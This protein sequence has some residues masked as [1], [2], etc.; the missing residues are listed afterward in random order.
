MQSTG[1]AGTHLPQPEH[2]S[3]TISTVKRRRSTAANA[4]GHALWHASQLMQYALSTRNG[5]SRHLGCRLRV[6]MRH[7]RPAVDIR[8]KL[9]D[10]AGYV[11]RVTGQTAHPFLSSEWIAEARVIHEAHRGKVQSKPPEIRLNLIVTEVPFGEGT[12]DAHVDTMSGE[13][14]VDLGHLRDAD[15]VLTLGYDTAKAILIEQD[16]EAAMKAF[17]GGRIK[18]DGDMTKLLILQS[19]LSAPDPVAAEVSQKIREITL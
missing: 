2:S 11:A 10:V 6:A 1:H 15:L 16:G 19:Q 5:A 4:G 3:G 7:G 12:L 13:L 17:L 8:P 18:I 9:R 14:E